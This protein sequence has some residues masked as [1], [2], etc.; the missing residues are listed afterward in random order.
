MTNNKGCG[1]YIECT[2]RNSYICGAHPKDPLCEICQ[3][4]NEIIAKCMNL[5][6]NFVCNLKEGI[7]KESRIPHT[8]FNRFVKIIDCYHE[9][10]KQKIQKLNTESEEKTHK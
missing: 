3:I 7:R 1:E 6:S 4:K 2:M 8:W 10:L 5:N 9:E